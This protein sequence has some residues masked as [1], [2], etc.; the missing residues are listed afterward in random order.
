MQ[1][2]ATKGYWATYGQLLL[3]NNFRGQGLELTCSY[4]RAFLVGCQR[5][6]PQL[7]APP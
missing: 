7:T 3:E 5:D 6:D 4:L 1:V 2:R